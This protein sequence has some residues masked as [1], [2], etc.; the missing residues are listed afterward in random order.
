MRFFWKGVTCRRWMWDLFPVGGGIL[1]FLM[2]AVQAW[3]AHLNDEKPSNS[4]PDFFVVVSKGIVFLQ[5][6]FPC[7]PLSV[8]PAL[9]SGIHNLT[10]QAKSSTPAGPGLAQV[11]T[12]QVHKGLLGTGGAGLIQHFPTGE[13]DDNGGGHRVH[14]LPSPGTRPCWP[15]GASRGF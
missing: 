10:H 8:W 13:M 14:F 6:Q 3:L 4:A 11:G 5:T 9:I 2:Q 1:R 15:T 12:C 7:T